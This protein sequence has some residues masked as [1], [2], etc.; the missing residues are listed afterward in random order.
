MTE[1]SLNIYVYTYTYMYVYIYIYIHTHRPRRVYMLR[2]LYNTYYKVPFHAI[3]SAD[4]I[5]LKAHLKKVQVSVHTCH[6]CSMTSNEFH[7]RNEKAFL[8]STFT[9]S[10]DLFINTVVIFLL[11]NVLYGIKLLKNISL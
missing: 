2:V 4:S 10:P 3:T 8:S 11:G 9:T 7:S 5:Q 6:L 1:C